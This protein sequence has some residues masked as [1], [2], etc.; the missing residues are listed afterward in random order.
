MNGSAT[1]GMSATVGGMG[2][3]MSTTIGG[4]VRDSWGM[5]A[6]ILGLSLFLNHPNS[7]FFKSAIPVLFERERACNDLKG[8][9]CSLM[10]LIAA[11]EG[12]RYSGHVLA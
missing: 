12:R 10:S 6:S 4:N 9:K 5:S 1:V 11:S 2:G 7:Y 8:L 3:G